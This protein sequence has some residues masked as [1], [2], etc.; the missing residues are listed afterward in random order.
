MLVIWWKVV[1]QGLKC[2]KIYLKQQAKQ[3]PLTF[4]TFLSSV[5]WGN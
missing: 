5:I 1:Q 4:P 2:E 3:L